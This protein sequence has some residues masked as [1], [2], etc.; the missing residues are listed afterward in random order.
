MSFA[1][2]RRGAA[3]G[4]QHLPRCLMACG[5]FALSLGL[6]AAA[7]AVAEDGVRAA[8]AA[9]PPCTY[10]ADLARLDHPLS[11]VAARLAS[12][13][14]VKIVAIGSSS[15]A[16]AGASS[17]AASY[18]SRLAVELARRLHND[19]ITVVNK[20]A[21]GEEASDMLARFDK[22]VI[23]ENPDLVLWQAGTNGLLRDVEADGT[24]ALINEGVRRLKAAG[25]DVVLIDPQFAPRVLAKP[26]AE[27]LVVR[28]AN[29]A[30]ANN[31]V[32]F[33][34]YALMRQW[35]ETQG[36]PFE[37]FISGDGLHMNDW[38]Y[39]CVARAL[40]VAIADAGTRPTA[41]A[42]VRPQR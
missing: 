34:R 13:Q 35:H 40:S 19:Q 39:A 38:S 14:P 42:A 18:P 7:V 37:T 9:P 10:S 29:I 33:R 1:N 15:T 2:F 30:K 28:L 22:D 4:R 11:H 27:D 21:N 20:G 36:L 24:A 41:T 5:L 26:G 17:P 3:V 32:V 23:A 8:A 16:G 12:G 6:P 31:V 25:A